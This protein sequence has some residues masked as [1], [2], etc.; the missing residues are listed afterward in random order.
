[1]KKFLWGLTV[2][3]IL[4][5]VCLFLV[6]MAA[7][8]M[9][10]PRPKVRDGSTLVMQLGGPIRERAPISFPIPLPGIEEA[11]TVHDYWLLFRKAAADRRIVAAVLIIDRLEIGWAKADEL[12][13]GIAHVRAA[14]KPVYAW[15]RNP[16]SREYWVAT[17]A[18]R[19][20]MSPEDLLDLKGLRAERIFV[21]R[22][23][24]KLGVQMEIEHAGKY[25]DAGDMF[26]RTGM[27]PE[28]RQVMESLLDGIFASLVEGIQQG[29]KKTRE[30]VLSLINQGPHLAREAE[31]RGLVDGLRFEDQVYG[32]MAA[33]L[34][35]KEILKLAHTAY[36]RVPP[37]EVGLEGGRQVA[38]LTAEGPI[39]RGEDDMEMGE[40]TIAARA[41]I[42]Q[43]RRVANDRSIAGVIVRIDSPG[44]DGVASDDILRELRLLSGKK[45]VVFSMSDT[46]ASGGYFIALTGDPVVAYPNTLTGS[47]GVLY[48]KANL[49]GLYD[50][51]GITK[52]I[53]KRG[54]NADWDSDYK[55]LDEEGRARLRGIL[56]E[57]YRAFVQRVAEARRRPFAEVEQLAQGRVWLGTQAREQRL[58][59]ELGG[60]DRAIEVLRAKAKWRPDEKI[61]LAPY[62]GRRSFLEQL[63]KRGQETDVLARLAQKAGVDWRLW[64][65]GGVMKL[66]P[67]GV[68]VQ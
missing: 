47:I 23:L 22:T 5:A 17:A 44:G 42:R 28:S 68:L 46:A 16:G 51:L 10:G 61:T 38:L 59:D 31:A 58:L 32:E 30:E 3:L 1:M 4:S 29:R 45:P 41:F 67:Y 14:G 15:L 37:A 8:R 2:G 18:E 62:P 9:A 43:V 40:P 48:G 20:Y 64:T 54:Q 24:D 60:L 39:W 11:A 53:L 13:R 19:I 52:D 25:K 49:R 56:D 27:S 66:A 26:T 34:K 55:P 7:L 21:R 36:A 12:R 63:L 33:R 50:K 65:P 6:A 57:F 35:Q